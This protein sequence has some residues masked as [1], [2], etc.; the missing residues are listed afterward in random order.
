MSKLSILSG[1]AAHGLVKAVEAQFTAATAQAIDG[2]FGAVGAMRAKLGAG[3]GTDVVILTSAIVRELAAA[4]IVASDSVTD[5]GNVETAIAIRT[6]DPVP[7]VADAEQL[8]LALIAADAIYF[9][10]PQQATAGIHFAGVLER[11][12]IT[13]AVASRL[14]TY[15]N[16]ATAM[17]ALADS[18]TDKHPIGCTQVTE[19]VATPGVT[20]IQSLPSGFGL[21]TVYTAGVIAGSKNQAA[22]RTLIG[23]LA[24]PANAAARKTCGF[25]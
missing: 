5:V 4:G 16:G 20:L 10:D 18:K 19:I 9:P 21:A 17:R 13:R 22:A 2:T 8:T 1:G 23:L 15:P 11:L 6:G 7:K 14:R 25:V 24:G 12:G 3:L